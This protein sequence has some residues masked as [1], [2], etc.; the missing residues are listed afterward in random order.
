MKGLWLENMNCCNEKRCDSVATIVMESFIDE[1]ENKNLTKK[2]QPRI[3][4]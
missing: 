1:C 2:Y 4:P 3:N